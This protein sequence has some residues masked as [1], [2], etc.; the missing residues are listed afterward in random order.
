MTTSRWKI[1]LCLTLGF[2]ASL[3]APAKTEVSL[4]YNHTVPP[5]E[6]AV[7]D[8]S[9]ALEGN[10]DSANLK[11]L[12]TAASA[13]GTTRLFLASSAEEA[14]RVAGELGLAPLKSGAPQSYALRRKVSAG[15]TN[16]VVLGAD[17]D[18]AMY[19]GLDLAEAIR[20]GTLAALADSDHTPWIAQR[21][22]KFNITLDR[23]SPT[24][25]DNSDSAQRNIP[26][27]WSMEFWHE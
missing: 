12:E 10:G 6:F 2:M 21:G 3:A 15:Q 16:Y 22:I 5:A 25:S 13:T 7:R 1:S 23:R 24:Y 9:R 17:A 4:F 20:L 27:M 14:K 19:G 8:I 18:G 26:E 11:N